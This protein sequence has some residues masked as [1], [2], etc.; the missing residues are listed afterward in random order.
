VWTASADGTRTTVGTAEVRLD[1]TENDTEND[2]TVN[3]DTVN[4]EEAA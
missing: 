4:D 1:V 3:D 2:D